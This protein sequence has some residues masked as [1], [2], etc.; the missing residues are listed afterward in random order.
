MPKK[1]SKLESKLLQAMQFL[2]VCQKDVGVN[3]SQMYCAIQN[4]AAVAFDGIIAAGIMI[5]EDLNCCPHTQ[6][7]ALA[8][9]RCSDTWTITQL[10]PETLQIRSEG[11]EAFVPCCTRERLTAVNPDAGN[12][13]VSD[14]L[15]SALEI[16]APLASDK[17]EVLEAASVLIEP[18]SV[19]A[20]NREMVMEVWHGSQLPFGDLL[21]PK[22]AAAA[23][24]KAKKKIIAIGI[25]PNLAALFPAGKDQNLHES[26]TFWFA[27]GSWIRSQLYKGKWRKDALALIKE[28][29]D[30]I[31]PVPQTFFQTV[32]KVMPFSEDGKIYCGEGKV[33][34]HYQDRQGAGYSIPFEDAPNMK[35]YK[36]KNLLFAGKHSTMIDERDDD[37]SGHITMFYGASTR[38]AVWHDWI[39]TDDDIPF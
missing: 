2:S 24:V 13:F 34:S 28:P 12:I 30:D 27:D 15:T 11:F 39:I 9:S 18:N 6:Q 36:G 7:M 25:K 14:S 32:A 33:A 38:C 3:D 17:A 5:D 10:S 29:S 1:S 16:V 20:T 23:I 21:I 26:I 8:L 37:K 35:I 22:M 31:R 19:F 4:H